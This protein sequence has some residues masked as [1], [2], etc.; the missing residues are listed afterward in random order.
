MLNLSELCRVFGGRTKAPDHAPFELTPVQ[1]IGDLSVLDVSTL[2][3]GLRT[4]VFA[5]TSRRAM[6]GGSLGLSVLGEDYGRRARIVLEHPVSNAQCEEI[7]SFIATHLAWSLTPEKYQLDPWRPDDNYW[8]TFTGK[9]CEY[10]R[11]RRE[12]RLCEIITSS[13][14]AFLADENAFRFVADLLTARYDMDDLKVHDLFRLPSHRRMA[15]LGDITPRLKPSGSWRRA[16][17]EGPNKEESRVW[18]SAISTARRRY[19]ASE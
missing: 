6:R 4:H 12:V 7:Y 9:C 19:L 15:F 3:A 8:K 14:I 13:K 16:L 5:R 2:N 10:I 1:I 17:C 18:S 11:T